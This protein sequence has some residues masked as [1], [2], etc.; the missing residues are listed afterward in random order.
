MMASEKNWPVTKIL[1]YTHYLQ[2]KKYKNHSPSPAIP[3]IKLDTT[4]HS[5][6]STETKRSVPSYQKEISFTVNA[7]FTF[8]E[9]E[10]K[11]S[12]DGGQRRRC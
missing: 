1:N 8:F 3:P 12:G 2:G 5:T 10:I 4:N 7:A 6:P 11:G 9:L